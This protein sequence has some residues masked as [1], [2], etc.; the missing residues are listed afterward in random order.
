MRSEESFIINDNS[1]ENQKTRDS[2]V[3]EKPHSNKEVQ[4]YLKDY[5][6]LKDGDIEK[7]ELIK[8]K[9]LLKNYQKQLEMLNDKRLN[10]VNIAIIPDNFWLKGNQPSE[11]DA[12]NNIIL[13]KESYFKSK[14]KP[15]EIAWM[16]HELSHCQIFLDSETPEDYQKNMEKFAFIDLN[17]KYPYPNNIVEQATFTNQ[18]QFLKSE[19]KNRVDI[20]KMIN[21]YYHEED[22][23]FFNRILDYI[24]K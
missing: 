13:I 20:L 11:S 23:P 3:L 18:F 14:E 6:D 21:N 8:A 12:E 7:L 16:T 10:N 19:G 17:S 15:D 2:I 1:L 5:L 4:Y 24:Y 9:D 22:L